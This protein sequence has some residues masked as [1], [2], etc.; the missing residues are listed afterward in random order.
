MSV[1]RLT[2]DGKIPARHRVKAG[3]KLYV[4]ATSQLYRLPVSGRGRSTVHLP[5]FQDRQNRIALRVALLG[6]K[7]VHMA[8]F[9]INNTKMQPHV[10]LQSLDGSIRPQQSSAIVTYAESVQASWKGSAFTARVRLRL[11]TV[12]P[13][14]SGTLEAGTGLTSV[15]RIAITRG[16]FPYLSTYR[17]VAVCSNHRRTVS[18]QRDFAI[19]H[20]VPD[21]PLI[22]LGGHVHPR[23]PVPEGS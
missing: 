18:N 16:S 3:I 5:I 17:C 6:I 1:F 15:G 9:S 23:P 13:G 21:M 7:F 8:G 19:W 2:P 10:A 14:P 12:P 20:F 11:S 4:F 22:C